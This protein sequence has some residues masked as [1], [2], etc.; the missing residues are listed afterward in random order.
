MILS[1]H[2][3]ISLVYQSSDGTAAYFSLFKRTTREPNKNIEVC[4]VGFETIP[5]FNELLYSLKYTR[6]QFQ[7]LE[8]LSIDCRI[9]NL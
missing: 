6:I 1:L 3:S 7:K 4:C 8:Y 2:V 9:T 5:I